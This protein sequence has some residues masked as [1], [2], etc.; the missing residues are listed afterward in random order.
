MNRL[1]RWF[2]EQLLK[3]GAMIVGSGILL[4]LSMQEIQ[5]KRRRR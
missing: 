2:R 4:V 3:L 1:E 5:Q